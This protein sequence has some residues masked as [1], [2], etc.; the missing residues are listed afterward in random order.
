MCIFFNAGRLTSTVKGKISVLQHLKH[1]GTWSA[2]SDK[3]NKTHIA[4]GSATDHF[5]GVYS[6]FHFLF[7][8]KAPFEVRP[9]DW[10]LFSASELV[11]DA[12]M[13]W[14]SSGK[15]RTICLQRKHSL[16]R[17]QASLLCWCSGRKSSSI[18][19][20]LCTP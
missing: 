7:Y 19:D 1:S 17:A 16:F 8:Q 14:N 9:A 10:R 18:L 13:N 6:Y 15:L 12:G 11:S 3:L 2:K 20:T 5:P 4:E